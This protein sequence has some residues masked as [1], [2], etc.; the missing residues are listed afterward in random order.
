M[1]K[2]NFDMSGF[3]ARRRRSAIAMA[4][5][6][7]ATIAGLTCL[8]LVLGTLLYK[9]LSGL[10]L[11]VFTMIGSI[12]FDHVWQSL[13]FISVGFVLHF[14]TQLPAVTPAL[15]PTRTPRRRPA[16]SADPPTEV[17]AAQ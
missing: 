5:S 8:A 11:A 15:S 10:S 4:L 17:N 12:T 9:G 13:Y 7:A 1:S 2:L 14:V 16:K 6:L 3:R